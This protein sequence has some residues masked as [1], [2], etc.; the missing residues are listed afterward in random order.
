MRK[1]LMP[2]RSSLI[3]NVP[4][5]TSP[6]IKS[7]GKMALTHYFKRDYYLSSHQGSFEEFGLELLQ[8]RLNTRV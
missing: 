3:L 1:S 7:S 6:T 2:N 4:V 5:A 8:R